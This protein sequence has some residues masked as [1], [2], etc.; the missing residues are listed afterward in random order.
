MWKEI[1]TSQADI[2]CIQE[3]HFHRHKTPKCSHLKFPV[4]LTASLEA[5]KC[6][7]LIAIKNTISFKQE[8]L[9]LD[10]VG[11]YIILICQINNAFYTIVNVYSPNNSQ[12]RFLEKVLPK[13]KKEQKGSLIMCGDF[14]KTVHPNVDCSPFKKRS[15]SNLAQLLHREELFDVWRCQHQ[16]EKDFTFFSPVRKMYSRID[17]I[18]VDKWVL[19]RSRKSLIGHI[20][21]SD[22]AP[23]TIEILEQYNFKEPAI[24]RFQSYWLNNDN[25]AEIMHSSLEEYF[26]HNDNNETSVMTLWLAHKAYLRGIA[27]Q[28]NACLKKERNLKQLTLLD[29][30]YALEQANKSNP[31]PDNSL[32]IKTIQ[33]E[34]QE[35]FIHKQTTMYNKM[36]LNYYH[37]GDKA[38]A[39]LA[40]RIKIS[41][42]KQRIPFLILVQSSHNRRIRGRN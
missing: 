23:I 2:A 26:L 19:Q 28:Q 40:K 8:R 39:L 24:W 31:T 14:N 27:I 30:L 33:K 12:I 25:F 35:L 38:S 1:L 21:W 16:G 17:L 5:K 11:R 15:K 32:Q 22:H 7:V 10:S 4:V 9:I 13:I 42:A 3:T 20:T 41:Q 34:L 29:R 6:G 37:Q 18:V 36:K